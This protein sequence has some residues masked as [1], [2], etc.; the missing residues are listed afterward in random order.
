MAQISPRTI[1]N[2]LGGTENL[3]D[4][5]PLVGEVE[6]YDG[7][8]AFGPALL[9]FIVVPSFISNSILLNIT[10]LISGLLA[11][12]GFIVLALKPSYI[13]L[14]QL[15][16]NYKA[17]RDRVDE[18]DGH[19]QKVL[20]TE[21]G[22]VD[23]SQTTDGF[24]VVTDDTRPWVGIKKI[25]PYLNAIERVD[26]DM[27]GII[28]VQG[29]NLDTSKA[30]EKANYVNNFGNFLGS[31]DYDY[32]FQLYVTN[33]KFDPAP[34][35]YKLDERVDNPEVQ[36]NDILRKYIASRREWLDNLGEFYM[37]KFY[38]IVSVSEQ[39]V[40]MDNVNRSEVEK[41]IQ[42]L[43]GGEALS[44][45]MSGVISDQSR[46]L[47]DE[48]VKERQAE[49]LNNRLSEIKGGVEMDEDQDVRRLDSDELGMLL[50]EFWEGVNVRES[51]KEDLV[52]EQPF[53]KKEG[54]N[55]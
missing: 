19:I 31:Q 25:Y 49:I 2:N 34:Y 43:P 11:L 50:K 24:E 32:E 46:L 9:F 33:K 48:E 23:I 7:V 4:D 29:I 30:A 41:N 47:S 10:Y 37:K 53:N 44:N 15:L 27:V 16:K 26:G 12:I 28:E 18:C 55:K 52:R 21:G 1:P 38:F 39:E 6:F 14:T 20:Q 17:Y 5:L 35:Q 54:D 51:E 8:I 3:F 13:S 22:E 45:I 40:Y 36:N 42:N